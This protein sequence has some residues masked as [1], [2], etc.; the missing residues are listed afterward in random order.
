MMELIEY[1]KWRVD[2]TFDERALNEVDSIL[3]CAFVYERFDPIFE[4][5]RELT[6]NQLVDYYFEMYDEE[7]LKKRITLANR[8]YEIVKAMKNTKRYGDLI[9]SHFVNEIDRSQDL[10]L[11]AMCFEYKNKWKY[12]AFRGTDDHIVG[13]KEDFNMIYK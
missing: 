12:I 2:L 5:H 7:Q 9:V 3:F 4:K 8:S 11:A 13:W 1:I 6:I 10:Q